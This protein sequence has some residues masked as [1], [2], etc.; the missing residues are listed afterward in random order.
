MPGWIVPLR[1][2]VVTGAAA[3][4]AVVAVLGLDAWKRQLKGQAEYD[5]AKRVLRLLYQYRDAIDAFRNPAMW[6]YEMPEPPEEEAAGMTPDQIRYYGRQ[7][8]YQAR[9]SRIRDVRAELYPELLE[10]EVLWDDELNALLKPIWKL[11]NDLY[12]A[13][14]DDLEVSKPGVVPDEVEH[15]T[16]RDESKRRRRLLYAR[17]G[18]EDIFA[19]E[20]QAGMKPLEAFLK[21][22]L[23]S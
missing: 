1:E 21:K 19:G 18:D 3:V 23:K 17:Y 6:N 11:E 22:R 12:F 20:F 14:Q 8:A 4:G 9:W 10:A 15:M 7:K 5:L 13:V 16:G 2:L